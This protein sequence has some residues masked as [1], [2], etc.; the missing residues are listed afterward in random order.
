MTLPAELASPAPAWERS[1]AAAAADSPLPQGL[2]DY[3]E[4]LAAAA[5]CY[6]RILQSLPA[7]CAAATW[8]PA[9]QRW[10]SA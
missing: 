8:N 4:A 6:N 2:H 9:A 7:T 10:D 1:W 3:T 5:R